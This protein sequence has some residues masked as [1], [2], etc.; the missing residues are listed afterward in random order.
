MEEWRAAIDLEKLSNWMKSEGFGSGKIENSEFLGGGTQ[1]VVLKFE[2]DG[3]HFV[4]RRPPVHPRKNSNETMR[5]EMRMLGALSGTSVPHPRLILGCPDESVLGVSFYLMEPVE[6]FTP[7]I[8]LPE[9]HAGVPSVRYQM[10]LNL[11]EGITALGSVDYLSVGLDGF[12]NLDNYLGR[13]V[14]RWKSQ[15]ESYHDLAGW[16]GPERIPGVKKVA[17]WLE[18][19]VP[20]SF[21]PGII[22]GDYHLGNVM[23]QFG[24][25]ELAAI[26][27]WEL[28]TVGD[29]LLDLGW[30]LATWPEDGVST[31]KTLTVDP[32]E[33]FP[34]GSELVEHY[35]NHSKRSVE[36]IDWY[37]VLACYKLG[38]IL[39]GT[40][41]RACAGKATKE[42]GDLLHAS[43]ISLFERALNWI[44]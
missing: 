20:A 13:Q 19:H 44:R 5:R 33:G 17:D 6:G 32:W 2:R 3:R 18:K 14:E 21:E 37:A 31:V 41:A 38:I 22:H 42:S 16:P 43:T 27:D 1:N 11:V 40:H 10:G 35:R 4:L 39:E 26:V 30:L 29:P 12:G 15:L 28:T 9:L 24:G 23:Y 25:P 8:E 36:A 7:T 34:S